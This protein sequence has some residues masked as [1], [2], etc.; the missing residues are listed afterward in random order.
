MSMAKLNI[1]EEESFY[2]S[3]KE[4]QQTLFILAYKKINSFENEVRDF[5]D[6]INMNCDKAEVQLQKL[7]ELY[8]K[9]HQ[10]HDL[11]YSQIPP[12]TI[13]VEQNDTTYNKPNPAY[14]DWENKMEQIDKILKTIHI[15]RNLIAS[16]VNEI[17]H[18]KSQCEHLLAEIGNLR[19][20]VEDHEQ[21]WKMKSRQI[22]DYLSET[23]DLSKEIIAF[24]NN[25]PFGSKYRNDLYLEV[26]PSILGSFS[27]SVRFYVSELQQ[28]MATP[29]QSIESAY[30]QWRDAVSE[31]YKDKIDELGEEGYEIKSSLEEVCCFFD[32]L[33]NMVNTYLSM[34]Y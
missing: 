3:V 4:L 23:I 9:A 10:K 33:S 26:D 30:P 22:L 19:S 16:W 27:N 31:E 11:Y 21:D 18:A 29:K 2:N 15:N 24:N 7:D 13:S 25:A 6:R 17:Q 5:S 1:Q 8:A 14:K 28:K 12:K 20:V 34:A 32:D